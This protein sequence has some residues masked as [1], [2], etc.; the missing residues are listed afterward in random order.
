[1]A[2]DLGTGDIPLYW[3]SGLVD[4]PNIHKLASMGVTFKDA[5]STPLCATSRYTLLSGNYPHRGRVPAG[6]WNLG[7]N[8]Q[9]R[10]F[11]KSIG[12][13]LAEG[14]YHTAMHGKW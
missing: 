6:T 2:D 3:N 8:S 11:Q 12:E 5:H 1:M 14:G 7:A 13:S 10:S 4:M 9:F